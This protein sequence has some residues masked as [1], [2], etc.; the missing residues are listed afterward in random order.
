MRLASILS[1]S[2]PAISAAQ[3]VD[4]PV[5]RRSNGNVCLPYSRGK[6]DHLFYNPLQLIE[7]RINYRIRRFVRSSP[8]TQQPLEL[9]K[10]IR[11]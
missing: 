1:L 11:T 7:F 10:R 6:L 5:Q 9:G 4:G 3:P 2:N 8:L